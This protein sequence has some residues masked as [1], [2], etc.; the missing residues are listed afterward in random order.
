MKYNGLT[1]WGKSYAASA[2]ANKTPID[3][4]TVKIGDGKIGTKE[5][6]LALLN[7][8]N[9][10]KTYAVEKLEKQGDQVVVNTTIHNIG[11][12]TAFVAREIGIYVLENGEEKLF[13]YIN[14]DEEVVYV[15]AVS[16]GLMSVQAKYHMIYA[17]NEVTVT[18]TYDYD[19][20]VSKEYMEMFTAA[21][22]KIHRGVTAP[23]ELDK[24]WLDETDETPGIDAGS[25]IG[26]E[27]LEI[28]RENSEKIEGMLYLLTKKLDCGVEVPPSP[29]MLTTGG[30]PPLEGDY[31]E[32]DPTY[33]PD[34]ASGSY[35]NLKAGKVCIR[36]GDK[37]LMGALFGGEFYYDPKA[38]EL[39]IGD[40]N[41]GI[42]LIGR[43][44]GSGGG[45]GG[46]GNLTG[47]YVELTAPR[48]EVF[49]IKVTDN[50]KLEITKASIDKLPMPNP[51]EPGLDGIFH[52]GWDNYKDDKNFGLCINQIYSGG[53]RN[54]EDSPVSHS[55]IELYNNSER[56]INLRGLS[57][58]VAKT[59][60]DWAVCPLDGVLPG[61]TSFLIRCAQNTNL[62]KLACR[63]K[64]KDYDID[65]NQ[66]LSATG[67]KVVLVVGTKPLDVENPFRDP[68]NGVPSVYR[69]IDMLGAG[70]KQSSEKVDYVEGY[71]ARHCLDKNTSICRRFREGVKDKDNNL[72]DTLAVDYR[73][74]NLEYYAPK[75]R[76]DG[77]W[78]IYRD[79]MKLSDNA[80]NMIFVTFGKLQST[81]IFT[82]QT[83]P[84]NDGFVKIKKIVNTVFKN[85]QYVKEEIAGYKRW[86]SYNSV[87]R[88]ISHHDTS[89][90]S[91]H[92]MVKDMTPGI[93]VYKCGE[94]GKWSDEYEIEVFHQHYGDFTSEQLPGENLN[95]RV[96]KFL[97]TSDQ[98]GWDEEEYWAW[99]H[100]SN[101]IIEN[102]KNKPIQATG[103][104]NYDWR[105]NTG[106]ESQNGNRSY[107]WRYYYDAAK[108]DLTS[109][110]EMSVAG[111]NDLVDKKKSEAFTYY[112]TYED[113]PYPSVYEYFIGDIH[114]IGF[115]TW[116]HV[117]DDYR[118]SDGATGF[119]KKQMEWV[120][121]KL[122]GPRKRWT[123][124]ISHVS[125]FTIVKMKHAQVYRN[126]IE[127]NNGEYQPVDLFLCGHHHAYSR[128]KAMLGTEPQNGTTVDKIDPLNGVYHVMCQAT[129]FKLSGK[130][131]PNPQGEIWYATRTD[132][133][134]AVTTPPNPTYIMWEIHKDYI[135]LNTYMVAGIIHT[136]ATTKEVT[137]G[138]PSEFRRELIDTFKVYHR[139]VRGD[140]TSEL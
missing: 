66:E 86:T 80:P 10:K 34:T 130:E 121:E 13:W 72:L 35:P 22:G 108:D 68:T 94:E 60:K 7:L 18:N 63:H 31:P 44:G 91:H 84:T 28:L 27:I 105:L 134:Y 138:N 50:G 118:D 85:G 110:V 74:C 71:F 90:V 70:G 136:N 73:Y 54:S 20:F 117:D 137:Y 125:P 126:M 120:M 30:K 32:L 128:S 4:S 58:Q 140:H 3:I 123:I 102:E 36:R 95:D 49:K 47:E 26:R 51:E 101:Y 1:A 48:G 119:V 127:G 99:K 114:F 46:S 116:A 109:T 6:A 12:Q 21:M 16:N 112:T 88:N 131:R 52:E 5:E 57:V 115:H 98:Q 41:G 33:T 17:S 92:V 75:C 65:W 55:F 62:Y 122:R 8:V 42:T 106:D 37:N 40:D 2:I 43:A 81:R 77:P 139:S 82:W 111:N 25:D 59:G 67:M 132:G 29:T 107:E 64:I 69:Y 76:D 133:S 56:D 15:R 83:K 38:K 93:Y 97:H 87:K 45:G 19:Y 23:A 100:A 9:F 96:V 78:D 103:K 135:Q 61:N 113:S 11:L 124:L 89:A 53:K 129:G 39:Y 104:P 14:N 79:K 24:L